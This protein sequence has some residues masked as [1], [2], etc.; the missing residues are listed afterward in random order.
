MKQK[1][2]EKHKRVIIV[3][4]VVIIFVAL[5]MFLFCFLHSKGIIGNS[6]VDKKV[7]L[8]GI[9]I[10]DDVA[11]RSSYVHS[12]RICTPDAELCVQDLLITYEITNEDKGLS[13][14]IMTYK[15]YN[16]SNSTYNKPLRVKLGDYK[17]AFYCGSLGANGSCEGKACGCEGTFG[18]ENF[19]IDY[20]HLD[21]YTVNYGGEGDDQT[22]YDKFKDDQDALDSLIVDYSA[23]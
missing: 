1:L 4:V 12:D 16:S 19:R 15:I 3:G 17:L 5:I 6:E 22:I 20:T 18:F 8:K 9:S 13:R 11:N 21:G 23:D 2:N 10:I 7:Q 14:G